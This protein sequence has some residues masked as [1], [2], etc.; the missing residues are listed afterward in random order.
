MFPKSSGPFPLCPWAP[1]SCPPIPSRPHSLFPSAP[2]P[3]VLVPCVL[4]SP[5]DV[6]CAFIQPLCLHALGHCVPC[7]TGSHG[8]LPLSPMSRCHCALCLHVLGLS[9]PMLPLPYHPPAVPSFPPMS[10]HVSPVFPAPPCSHA[11]HSVCSLMS[12]HVP[13]FPA[14]L[15]SS[16]PLCPKAPGQ[17]PYGHAQ[18]QPRVGPAPAGE[19]KGPSWPW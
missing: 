13:P 1:E 10:Q 17:L 18:T 7:A 19:D 6:P 2:V 14:A 8:L 3:D 4:C 15:P 5:A 12:I 11:L 9:V 16:S